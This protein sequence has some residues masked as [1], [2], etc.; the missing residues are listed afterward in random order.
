MKNKTKQKQKPTLKRDNKF[1]PKNLG[2]RNEKI[3][4]QRNLQFLVAAF[5]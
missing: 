2:N 1:D 4:P 3:Y 5:Q